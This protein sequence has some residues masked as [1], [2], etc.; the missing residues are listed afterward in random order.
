MT[1]EFEFDDEIVELRSMVREFC[2]EVS[3]EARVR[4]HME[5]ELGH[6][7]ALWR[8]L[9]TDI[10]VLGLAVPEAYGGDDVGLVAQAV[11]VE[12]L[13]AAL[14]C[15]P[16]LGTLA[17]AM[18]TLVAL[19]DEDAKRELLPP[20]CSGERVATLVAP[21]AT[22]VLDED[23]V[24][25]EATD[26]GGWRL[27]GNVAQV[28]DGAAADTLLVLARTS[29]GMAL[30]AVAGGAEGLTRTALTTLDLTRR[31][32][33]V[34]FAATP[35]QL[36][37]SGTEAVGAVERAALVAS[38]LLAVESVGGSQRMLDVTVAHV[39]TR[40]QFG[41]PVGA[42]QAVKHRCANLLIAVEA[43]RSAAYHGAWALQDGNDDPRLA[44]GLAKAV[45]S[46]SYQAVSAGAI[47]L[48]GG[49][50]FT[51]EGSPHLYF[52]RAST[53]GLTLGTATQHL[54]RVAAL[55]LDAVPA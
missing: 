9:G 49:L 53:N 8:R 28:P 40:K 44:A 20:L 3:P 23:A 14:V 31:Q 22:G 25:V 7:P 19:S 5:S 48:H 13:G 55:T 17:L 34:S 42:F 45:A 1:Q 37:A 11:V 18:P 27:T 12:E 43:A 36:L 51:W 46:E 33:A 54:D 35:A 16:V 52:K 47:Q 4:E 32:A 41:Q 24:T 2:A 15:G 30:F 6:D 50:G 29:A 10:G 39:S 26:N 21:L 38:V